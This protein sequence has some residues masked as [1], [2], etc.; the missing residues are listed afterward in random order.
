[1]LTRRVQPNCYR[2]SSPVQEQ[3]DRPNSE[4]EVVFGEVAVNFPEMLAYRGSK[5]IRMTNMGFKM[6]KYLIQNARRVI[7]R[8]ELLNEV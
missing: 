6:L 5:P 8:D 7:S 2:L 3:I 1:V 4:S